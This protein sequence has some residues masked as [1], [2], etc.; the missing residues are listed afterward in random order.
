MSVIFNPASVGAGGGMTI[1]GAIVGGTSPDLLYVAPGGVLG[2]MAS[3]PTSYLNSGSGAS[4]TTFWRGDGTW[5]TPAGGGGMSIGGSIVGGTAGEALMVGPGSVLA[6]TTALPV[7]VFDSGTGANGGT[8]WR[9]DGTWASTFVLSSYTPVVL[10]AALRAW[11]EMDLLTGASGSSQGTIPDQSGNGYNLSQATGS[12]Q[13]TLALADLN[14]LNTLRFTQSNLTNYQLALA[15]L[16]GATAGSMYM[17][18][19]ISSTSNN[20]AQMA[21]GSSGLANH[22]PYADGSFYID[23]GSTVRSAF[24]MPTGGNPS[25]AY[26]IISVYSAL[27]DWA[28]YIDGGH[29]GSAGGTTPL[30]STTTNTVGWT[31]SAPLLGSAAGM[32]LDGWIAEIYFTNAKQST[33]DR[34][35]NEGYLAWKWGLQGNLDSSHPYKGSAPTVGASLMSIGAPVTGGTP[36]SVLFLD[37]ASKLA[38]DN[39]N[40]FWDDTNYILK[41]GTK[42]QLISGGSVVDA[43]YPV[44]NASGD[45]WFVAGAGNS[46]VTGAANFGFGKGALASI[47]TGHDNFANGYQALAAIQQDYENVAIGRGALLQLGYGGANAGNN[48]R[49]YAM[50]HGTLGTMTQG[51]NNV[52]LGDQVASTVTNSNGLTG[53]GVQAGQYYGYGATAAVNSSIFIGYQAGFNVQ[54]DSQTLTWIGSYIGIDTVSYQDCI[55]IANGNRLNPTILD[56]A[57]TTSHWLPGGPN[58]STWSFSIDRHQGTPATLHIYNVQDIPGTANNFERGVL[59]WNITAN[60]FRIGTQAGGSGTVRLTAYDAFSKAGA[61]AATDLPAGTCAFIDDTTNNQTWLVFNK[62]GTIRKVQLT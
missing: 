42:I 41:A 35:K 37:S 50:G 36:N 49:N 33:L 57:V 34:Q 15:I 60:V 4:S 30:Y 23:F 58:Y 26:R 12:R 20:N 47:T 18:Y 24:A 55:C 46:S 28:F 16:S 53:I 14:G 13:G 3:L 22:W 2:Q 62:A 10:G 40:F 9:G 19:K 17:V 5:A 31:A 29:G 43:F 32:Y 6:Q 61:P 1:G 51:Q 7:S 54:N 52:A 48:F 45:N 27:N 59:D 21:W 44:Y 56:Y 11:Y 8:F 39:A 38:Q 25:T